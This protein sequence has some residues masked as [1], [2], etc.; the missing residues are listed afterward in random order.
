M[1]LEARPENGH[2]ARG[3]LNES[4]S[5]PTLAE[6]N[7]SFQF[8]L[9]DALGTVRDVVDDSGAV[10]QSYEFN[11]HGIPMPGSGAASGTFAPKTYQGGLSVNDD[12]NDSGLYLMGHR[13]FDA[14]LGRFISRDPIG[15]GGGLNLFNGH[16][17]SPVTM[18]DPFGLQP[19]PR[20]LTSDEM[21]SFS[22]ALGLLT[23]LGQGSN[24]PNYVNAAQSLAQLD[25]TGYMRIND[26]LVTDL[27]ETRSGLQIGS[28][29][30]NLK[31]SLF[32]SGY[33][34]R[35]CEFPEQR[36]DRAVLLAGVL[37]HENW[38][39]NNF[40][41]YDSREPQAWQQ[42]LNFYRDLLL[43]EMSQGSPEQASGPGCQS[44]LD[45]IWQI[46]A[47]RLAAGRKAGHVPMSPNFFDYRSQVLGNP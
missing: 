20:P 33:F 24:H 3:S 14:D 45:T 37:H 19:G 31:S 21:G 44:R 6:V 36:F 23:R 29:G 46:G 22:D 12:R 13:H 4:L 17:V 35:L 40:S 2:E 16:G 28:H 7:G 30:V 27:G 18:V 1:L 32:Y 26:P 25:K 11:E 10:I 42:E 38:H 39:W 5:D 47:D 15:F 41:N 8:F 9:T 34:K 43:Y